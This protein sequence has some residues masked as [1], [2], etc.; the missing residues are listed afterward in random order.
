MTVRDFKRNVV[1]T[2]LYMAGIV[3]IILGSYL[4]DQ[5]KIKHDMDISSGATQKYE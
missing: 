1:K 4:N 2:V 5:Y 3:L